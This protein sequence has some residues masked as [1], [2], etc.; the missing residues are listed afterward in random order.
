MTVPE[1]YTFNIAGSGKLKLRAKA[2]LAEGTRED[3]FEACVLLHEAARLQ[4]RATMALGNLPPASQLASLVEECWC[5]VEGR[6]P[7]RAA[8]VWGRV[9]QVRDRVE[10]PT[11]ISILGRIGA[12][13][14][15]SRREF[16][17]AVNASPV[18][19]SL[20]AEQSGWMSRVP[21]AM[22]AKAR[23]ELAKVLEKFPGAT[24]FWWMHYRLAE[25][26]DDRKEAWDGL[27]RAMRLAPENTRYRAMSFLIAAWALPA[28][29]AEQHIAS[30][31]TTLDRSSS[32]ECLMYAHAELT[33]ARKGPVA[34]RKTR[35]H[36]AR[37]AAEIGL[38]LGGSIGL[39]KDLRAVQLLVG[40]LLEGR[41]PT[42][43]VL[44]LAGL[45]EEATLAKPKVNLT[46][47]LTKRVRRTGPDPGRE[48][49]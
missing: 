7:P 32:E 34:E 12:H 44:Y 41:E 20:A 47:Y 3:L 39:R 24:S 38:S 1:E 10:P 46:E 49:A 17:R 28:A 6:D 18:L 27:S 40:E 19:V 22:V 13:F 15:K 48:A 9:L 21:P 23:T 36:R 30:V 4:H 45:G 29:A 37:E 26:A 31:R 2:L 43:D 25:L 16:S 42:I 8:D 5:Y 11:A 33:L 35:W 14:E